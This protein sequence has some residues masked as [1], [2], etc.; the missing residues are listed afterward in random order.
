MK[1]GTAVYRLCVF[2]VFFSA[3]LGLSSSSLIL[4]TCVAALNALTSWALPHT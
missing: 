3:V 1:G 2:L 4:R